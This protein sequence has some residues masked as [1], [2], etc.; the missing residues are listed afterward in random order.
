MS[1]SEITPAP[2]QAAVV[3]E[4]TQANLKGP[5]AITQVNESIAREQHGLGPFVSKKGKKADSVVYEAGAEPQRHFRLLSLSEC[6]CD[7]TQRREGVRFIDLKLILT[8]GLAYA[9]LNS[10]TAMATSLSIALPSGGP[11][12]VV[13]G[14]IV[15]FLGNL[16]MSASL[17][18]M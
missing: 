10:W 6:S 3:E 11:T 17:A 12:A 18:E 16:A 13:W 8:V 9:I 5:F 15:S 1:T 2:R 14:L 7:N 4:A